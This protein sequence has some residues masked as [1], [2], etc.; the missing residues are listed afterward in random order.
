MNQLSWLCDYYSRRQN[1]MLEFLVIQEFER[2]TQSLNEQQR[3]AVIEE[4][5]SPHTY[6]STFQ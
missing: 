6:V 4:V 5:L 1:N 2:V 3:T